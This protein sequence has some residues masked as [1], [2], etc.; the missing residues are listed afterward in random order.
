[1]H[2]SVTV[3]NS[4]TWALAQRLKVGGAS[5]NTKSVFLGKPTSI[6]DQKHRPVK[7]AL[8]TAPA[9]SQLP[10]RGGKSR[11]FN[12]RVDQTDM[13]KRN[14]PPCYCVVTSDYSTIDP[15]VLRGKA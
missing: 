11:C 9:T 7:T 6:E 12:H 2:Q 8:G 15:G 4:Y 13:V 3:G 5:E 10:S 14:P 1:M